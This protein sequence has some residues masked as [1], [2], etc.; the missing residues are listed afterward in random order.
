MT[1]IR[2][3]LIAEKK[4]TAPKAVKRQAS[5]GT[6]SELQE[7]A[8]LIVSFLLA[9]AIAMGIA[10][11]IK[12]EAQKRR[13]EVAR[14]QAEWEEVKIWQ[15]KRD[16]YEIRKELLNDQI[17]KISSLKDSRE[18]PVQLMVDVYNIMPDSVWLSDLRQGY[19]NTLIAAADDGRKTT[20]LPGRNLGNPREF[21]LTGFASS[22][23]AAT[24]FANR[25]RE[26]NASYTAVSL[27]DLTRVKEG[28]GPMSF[29][30]N[31]YFE[32]KP[33]SAGSAKGQGG[34]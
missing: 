11:Y 23:E 9:V 10:Y 19:P 25:L 16:E 33:K 28:D 2:I 12:G 13:L 4:A 30:F 3:N 17:A 1:M 32:T 22:A 24:T 7:N 34:S 6:Q 29:L 15:E 27:N 5:G 26:M 18:G 20:K 31:L 14:L 21:L 8:I